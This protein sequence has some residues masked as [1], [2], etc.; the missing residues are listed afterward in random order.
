M[1]AWFCPSFRFTRLGSLTKSMVR[2]ILLVQMCR[3]VDAE[4][5]ESNDILSQI[6]F[7]FM[8]CIMLLIQLNSVSETHLRSTPVI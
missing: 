7:M 8:M 3:Q 4:R 5:K 1:Y 2:N 6:L